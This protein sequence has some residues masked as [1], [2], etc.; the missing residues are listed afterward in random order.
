MGGMTAGVGWRCG[1]VW[2]RELFGVD[3]CFRRNDGVGYEG[4]GIFLVTLTPALS[5]GERGLAGV[6][7]DSEIRI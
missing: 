3:S 1:D 7:V 5:L 6:G 4:E 2:R